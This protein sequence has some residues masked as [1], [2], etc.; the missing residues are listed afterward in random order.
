M[1]GNNSGF[2]IGTLGIESGRGKEREREEG[3]GGGI[4]RKKT[5]LQQQNGGSKENKRNRQTN[6]PT[7]HQTKL[8]DF[9]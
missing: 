9:S 6:V 2:G 7:E 4:E 3:G 5:E 8:K 1:K